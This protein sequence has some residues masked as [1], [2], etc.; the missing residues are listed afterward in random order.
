M[1]LIR[2]FAG[3]QNGCR[4]P[5]DY[6]PLLVIKDLGAALKPDPDCGL[7]PDNQRRLCTLERPV[8]DRVV[9]P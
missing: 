5:R 9:R 7:C 4:N 8:F 3:N 6:W 1:R 2:M